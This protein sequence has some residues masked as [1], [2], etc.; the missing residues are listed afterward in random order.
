MRN[1]RVDRIFRD[2]AFGARIIIVASLFW[3]RA[4][5]TLRGKGLAGIVDTAE[6]SGLDAVVNVELK[7]ARLRVALPTLSVQT[8]NPGVPIG[9]LQVTGRYE[10]E[11]AK[12]AQGRL[13]WTK[14]QA[15]V[16]GGRL[17]LEPGSLTLGEPAQAL[18]LRLQGL[19]I[20]ELLRAYAK[21]RSEPAFA[22]LVRRHLNLVYSVALRSVAGDTYLAEDV[23]QQVFA[24]L[25][26]KA[27]AQLESIK[28]PA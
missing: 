17:W 6:F 14:A 4:T 21:D 7:G 15:G 26:A 27:V 25:A 24:D 11:L 12:P 22:E 20:A 10:G 18:D 5:L 1:R 9:P 16:L 23:T 19:Q 8:L 28:L 13:S 2:I 3:Q